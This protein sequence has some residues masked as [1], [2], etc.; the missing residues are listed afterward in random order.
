[1]ESPLR[2]AYRLRAESCS[3]YHNVQR[4]KQRGNVNATQ[5]EAAT[6]QSG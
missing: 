1:M 4:I 6:T 3:L 5:G 2:S